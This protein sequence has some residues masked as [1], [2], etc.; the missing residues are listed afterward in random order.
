MRRI[1]EEAFAVVRCGCHYGR[2]STGHG[3][4]KRWRHSA[5]SV[6]SRY[7]LLSW[8]FVVPILGIVPTKVTC[9]LL[10]KGL[11]FSSSKHAHLFIH[12]I[13]DLGAIAGA[14]AGDRVCHAPQSP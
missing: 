3:P 2:F 4:T 14:I 11:S 6:P 5:R 9:L 1:Y 10:L 13:R 12:A 7:G 8:R